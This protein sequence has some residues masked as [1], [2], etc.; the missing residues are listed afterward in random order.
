M[1]AINNVKLTPGSQQSC[2]SGDHTRYRYAWLPA[3]LKCSSGKGFKQDQHSG[4]PFPQAQL[5]LGLAV[6]AKSGSRAVPAVFS[7]R[8]E[9]RYSHALI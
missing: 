2:V 6:G 3:A 7:K 4:I 5:C 8:L 1:L 9:P